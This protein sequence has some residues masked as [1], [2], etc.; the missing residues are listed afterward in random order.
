MHI[1]TITRRVWLTEDGTLTRHTGL[2]LPVFSQQW[3]LPSVCIY[4]FHQQLWFSKW[5]GLLPKRHGIFTC[6][7]DILFILL[8]HGGLFRGVCS[9]IHFIVNIILFTQENMFED[10]HLQNGG[11][12]VIIP[13]YT[14]ARYHCK[15]MRVTTQHDILWPH[16]TPQKEDVVTHTSC[17]RHS[18]F[19][20]GGMCATL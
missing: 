2:C 16:I 14:S 4:F 9:L 10:I 6:L 7:L 8:H 12:Y 11:D 5:Y 17:V 3:K 15:H 1:Y 19:F 13:A 20:A 18:V